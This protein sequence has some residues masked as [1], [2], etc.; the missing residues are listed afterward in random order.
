MA[1]ASMAQVRTGE[2]VQGVR[3]RFACLHLKVLM[4][5]HEALLATASVAHMQGLV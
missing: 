2:R 3:A 5:T 4:F 1:T